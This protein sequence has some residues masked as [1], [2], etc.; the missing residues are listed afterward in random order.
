MKE[1]SLSSSAERAE[2]MYR[3]LLASCW[4]LARSQQLR[5]AGGCLTRSP[6]EGAEVIVQAGTSDAASNGGEYFELPKGETAI[7]SLVSSEESLDETKA[8]ELWKLSLKICK[9]EA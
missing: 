4:H 6:E 7:S 8:K 1:E 5:R 3:P 2:P 9:L